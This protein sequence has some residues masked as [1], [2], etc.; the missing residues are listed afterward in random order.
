[1]CSWH[2]HLVHFHFFN[3]Y[4]PDGNTVGAVETPPPAP[5]RLQW[6]LENEDLTKAIDIS[7]G[8]AQKLLND[9]DLKI[10]MF[11]KYGKGEWKKTLHRLWAFTSWNTK[12]SATHSAFWMN[13]KYPAS[14]ICQSV[15]SYSIIII[16]IKLHVFEQ[17]PLMFIQ[18]F[19]AL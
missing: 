10:L 13:N 4:A 15:I 8:V 19:V 17:T 18:I 1:M 12:D 16:K 11:K 2:S 7:Y 3:S 14:H 9:V 6:E 5:I